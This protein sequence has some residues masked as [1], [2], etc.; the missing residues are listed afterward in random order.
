[1][2]HIKA[3]AALVSHPLSDIPTGFF[4]ED[5]DFTSSS[6]K[7]TSFALTTDL[8]PETLSDSTTFLRE[9]PFSFPLKD[10]T[11]DFFFDAPSLKS[12]PLPD[13][14]EDYFRAFPKSFPLLDLQP[15]DMQQG[16]YCFTT[17]L[18][19]GNDADKDK[20]S[21]RASG[22]ESH[23]LTDIEAFFFEEEGEDEEGCC[24]EEGM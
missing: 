14:T 17:S 24:S 23:P 12:F 9:P 1:M 7:P 5:D 10:L 2:A 19:L 20:G 15:E 18:V 22:L 16:V 21:H 11:A 4:F 13:V 3:H 8:L 6:A